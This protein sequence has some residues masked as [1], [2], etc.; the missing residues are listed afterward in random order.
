MFDKHESFTPPSKLQCIWRHMDFTKLVDLLD[1]RELFFARADRFSDI[2]EGSL[3]IASA[4]YRK[5]VSEKLVNSGV[6]RPEYRDGSIQTEHT[7]NMLKGVAI[8]STYHRLVNAFKVTQYNIRIGVVKYIDYEKSLIDTNSVFTPFL[9]KRRSF[10]HENELR[11][12]LWGH[13]YQEPGMESQDLQGMCIPI[14]LE[15]LIKRIYVAP[16][17]P[18]WINRLVKLLLI[19][20]SLKWKLSSQ[21]WTRSLYI[22]VAKI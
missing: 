4:N 19:A 16:G 12:L 10:S 9:H 21:T 1:T 15:Q 22:E 11:A 5:H 8:Q 6:L 2:F 7:R 17:S 18:S 13:E 3:P 14:D 20:T